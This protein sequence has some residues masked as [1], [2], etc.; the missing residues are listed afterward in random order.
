MRPQLPSI[1]LVELL[2]KLEPR[3]FLVYV[4]AFFLR[5]P[6][7]EGAVKDGL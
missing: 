1:T 4:V 6:G 5:L 2:F 3:D 7:S